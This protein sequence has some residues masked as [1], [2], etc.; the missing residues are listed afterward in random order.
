MKRKS[1]K[2]YGYNYLREILCLL[3]DIVLDAEEQ[4]CL[5]FVQL[6]QLIKLVELVGEGLLVTLFNSL[7]EVNKQLVLSC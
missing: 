3:L 1:K 5:P 4:G 2:I 6:A 7:N